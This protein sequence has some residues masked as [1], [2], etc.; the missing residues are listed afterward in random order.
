MDG[1]AHLLV[2]RDVSSFIS[3][4]CKIV[5]DVDILNQRSQDRWPYIVMISLTISGKMYSCFF[6]HKPSGDLWLAAEAAGIGFPQR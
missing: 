4:H 3:Y 2:V 1:N 6:S 5:C